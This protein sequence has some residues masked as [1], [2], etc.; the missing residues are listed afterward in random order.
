[1]SIAWTYRPP[2]VHFLAEFGHIY[3]RGRCCGS[4]D[5]QILRPFRELITLYWQIGKD[6][7]TSIEGIE[8]ELAA[9]TLPIE[10]T[11]EDA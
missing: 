4:V 7:L 10:Y 9:G 1:M 11:E 3:R 2:S 6:I 8:H 5:T